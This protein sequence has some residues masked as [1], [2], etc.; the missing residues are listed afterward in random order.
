ML[1][2]NQIGRLWENMLSAEAR[3]LY[4]AHLGS[5]YTLT[6]Q[7][8]TGSSFFLASGAAASVVGKLPEWVPV[9]LATLSA[10]ATAYSMA[11]NLDARAQTM[12]K[13]HALWSRLAADYERLWNHAYE[14]GAEQELES[15]IA[16]E[17]E[18]SELAISSARYDPKLLVEWEDQVFKMHRLEP[19]K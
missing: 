2:E 4:F 18:P 10:A 14:D 8:L 7:W 12:T 1:N 16:R 15:V 17:Q 3:S 6:K 11:V 13:L 9:L 19:V 5:R